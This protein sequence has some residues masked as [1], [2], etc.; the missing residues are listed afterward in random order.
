MKLDIDLDPGEKGFAEALHIKW[1]RS[2]ESLQELITVTGNEVDARTDGE[3]FGGWCS[4][5]GFNPFIDN[6]I[7]EDV[8]V[9]FA[10]TAEE[11]R[12]NCPYN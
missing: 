4:W 6:D 9:Y 1:P 10:K 11:K 8:V 12:M 7:T 2:L 5:Y 3:S